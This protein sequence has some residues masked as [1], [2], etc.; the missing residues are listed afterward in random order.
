MNKTSSGKSTAWILV[1]LALVALLCIVTLWLKFNSA[2]KLESEAKS[3]DQGVQVSPKE[4][5]AQGLNPADSTKSGHLVSQV[6]AQVEPSAAPVVLTPEDQKKFSILKE[7]F[8]SKNDND[9][10][11]D[12]ELRHLSPDLKAAFKQEYQKI[13]V[14]KRNERGTLAFLLG[15]DL[16][17][18][19]ELP[20][21]KSIL[22][23]PPCL[24]LSNCNQVAAPP[25]GEQEHL[26]SMNQTTL[27]YPQ[28]MTLRMAERQ[29]QEGTDAELKEALLQMIKE[30]S[31][32]SVGRV[33][34][35][36][37]AILTRLGQ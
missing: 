34:Q 21:F 18:V 4:T 2:P 12:S 25:T 23:E 6:S 29:I 32:S 17:S 33:S 36:A 9:P 26:E 24:S 13:P 22:N 8:A 16:K 7:I 14:E 28:I 20:F 27:F 30:A 19:D 31:Q 3:A 10:R 35:E 37:H 11:L 15:R 5:R 1:L